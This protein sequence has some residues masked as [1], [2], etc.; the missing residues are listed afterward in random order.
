M[1]IDTVISNGKLVFPWGVVDG[2]LHIDDGKI[3]GIS[4]DK[5]S[6]EAANVIDASGKHVLAGMI[7]THIHIGWPDT[8]FADDVGP[9]TKAAAAGGTTTVMHYVMSPESLIAGIKTQKAAFEEGS[10]VDGGFHGMIFSDKNIDEIPEVAALGVRSFKLFLPYRGSEAVPPA[11]GID[12]GILYLAFKKIAELEPKG[13]ALV[14]AENIEIFFHLKDELLQKG[15]EDFDWHDTRP[16]F[17]EVESIKRVTYF[18]ELTGCPV[19]IVHMSAK[20]GPGEIR[21]ARG[22]GVDI[23]GET[24]PQYLTLTKKSADRVL[25]KV[26]P[27]L[28]DVDDNDALWAGLRDGT[29]SCIGSDH[30]PCSTKHKEE[31]WSAVVGFTGAQ[32]MLP[33]LLHAGVSEGRLRLE[34]L[35]QINRNNA[36][37]FGL[38]P[39]KGMLAVGA[40]ADVVIIDLQNEMTIRAAE[41]H[42][43]ADFT[44]FEGRTFRGVPE[45]T[46]LRGRVVAK[47]REVLGSAE[48]KFVP[49]FPSAQ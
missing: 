11:V 27:P 26:N 2:S 13:R 25:G 39:R 24:C 36:V 1:K 40:D 12:D 29:I 44:P 7:D 23:I 33:A 31:F 32:T 21:S 5:N 6:V 38:A 34:E 16:N 4:S 42:D 14:H 3:I 15:G 45:L 37:V 41:M 10:F 49:A 43:L 17:S 20:E 18:A 28:R 30:A 8:D 46:M 22:R 48:G 47:D 35:A 9:T 19:Y